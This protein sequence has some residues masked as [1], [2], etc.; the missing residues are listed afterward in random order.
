MNKIITGGPITYINMKNDMTP[1]FLKNAILLY[2]GCYEN[3]L[4]LNSTKQ[5]ILHT[6]STKLSHQ[7]L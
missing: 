5:L 1:K 6:S 2:I 4:H 3:K 7:Y